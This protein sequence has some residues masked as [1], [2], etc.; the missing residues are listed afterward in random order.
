VAGIAGLTPVKTFDITGGT[1]VTEYLILGRSSN[2]GIET[3]D[4]FTQHYY[5]TVC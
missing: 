4:S 2:M 3:R 5:E 1:S